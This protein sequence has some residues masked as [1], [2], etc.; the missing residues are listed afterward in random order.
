MT[1]PQSPPSPLPVGFQRW[2]RLLFLHWE[3]PAPLL[4][5]LVPAPLELDLYEG[6]AFVS[7]VA[8][9]MEDIR[10]AWVPR[11]W[12]LNFLETNLRTY[13]RAPGGSPAPA[14]YFFSLD[15]SSAIAV[16]TARL[17]WRLPYYLSRM[18][19]GGTAERQEY[20]LERRWGPPA[21]LSVAYGEGAARGTAV[22]GTLDHFLVER[23]AF[24]YVRGE[25]IWTGQVRHAPYP[26]QEVTIL[27]VEEEMLAGVGLRACDSTPLAHGSPGVEVAILPLGRE[28]SRIP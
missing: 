18:G 12:G 10:T 1:R 4:R 27:R 20:R 24:H 23:Y 26:L 22:A 11:G 13:V 8:F 6:R 5:P 2:T 3:V 19:R 28:P 14:V 17:F 9:S 15:A 7:L 25:G 21:K 16:A